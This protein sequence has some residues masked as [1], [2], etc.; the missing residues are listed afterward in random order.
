[1]LQ[2]GEGRGMLEVRQPGFTSASAVSS[3]CGG[4]S[5]LMIMASECGGASDLMIMAVMRFLSAGNRSS[6]NVA[7]M[8]QSTFDFAP[9]IKIAG[10]Q[11]CAPC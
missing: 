7:F 10:L 1:M 6:G 3:E 8:S 11:R 4:A 9:V 2:D 5:D